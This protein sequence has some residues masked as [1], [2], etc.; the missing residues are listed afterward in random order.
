MKL[1]ERIVT[2]IHKAE[3]I[4]FKILRW[5]IFA[6]LLYRWF[7]LGETLAGTLDI[8]I[9]WL[10]A[11]LAEFIIMASRGI[12]ISYPVALTNKEQLIFIFT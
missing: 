7:F 1:D 2:E 9:V 11:S 5:G 6:V 8:F 3:S 4:G 12:P 10:V